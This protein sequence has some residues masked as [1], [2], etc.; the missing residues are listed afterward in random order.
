MASDVIYGPMQLLVIGFGQAA[1]PLDFVNQ[2]RRLRDDGVIRLV[3]AVYVAKDEHGDLTEIRVTDFSE[4]EM[5]IFGT[6]AGALF[7]FGAA[8]EDGAVVGAVIGEMAAEAEEFGLDSD[9]MDEIADRIP[10]GSSAAFILLEHLWAIGLKES[11]RNT[12][13]AVIAHGWLTPATLIA[14][15]EQAAAVAEAGD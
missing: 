5:A 6:L 7:G 12:N 8:G 11:L 4:E 10:R 15:G 14:M 1:L 2:L 13:G 9:D 3:D